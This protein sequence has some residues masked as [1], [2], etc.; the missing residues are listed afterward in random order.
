VGSLHWA[1]SCL[2][3]VAVGLAPLLVYWL[4]WLIGLAIR[5]KARRPLPSVKT[6]AG[7]VNEQRELL[8]DIDPRGGEARQ[9][10]DRP[11]PLS[12][13]RTTLALN[14]ALCFFRVR[15]MSCSCATG[16]F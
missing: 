12:L 1:M 15:F 5:R 7:S 2:I 3:V 11:G 8:G 14:P 13:P 10:G 6:Q 9:F 4:G 16:A